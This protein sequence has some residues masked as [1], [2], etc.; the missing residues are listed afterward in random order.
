[1]FGPTGNPQARNLF[2]VLRH[3]QRQEGVRLQVQALR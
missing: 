2:E 3:I 1:M